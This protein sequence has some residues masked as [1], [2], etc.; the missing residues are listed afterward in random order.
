VVGNLRT[1]CQSV[2]AS[3][4]RPFAPSRD[5]SGARDVPA[6]DRL[7][8][9]G[10]LFLF[11]LH[12]GIAAHRSAAP[13]GGSSVRDRRFQLAHQDL[14][15]FHRDGGLLAAKREILADLPPGVHQVAVFAD[16]VR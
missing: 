11:V 12:R 14:E 13:A 3:H 8:L 10:T 16:R 6:R 15:H 9:A 2:Q 7:L 5:V 1:D 4:A